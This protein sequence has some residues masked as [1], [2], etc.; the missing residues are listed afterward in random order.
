MAVRAGAECSI[1][2]VLRNFLIIR[3]HGSCKRQRG[4]SA[5]SH[6]RKWFSGEPPI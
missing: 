3:S 6:M 4:G 1:Q 2:R 5:L